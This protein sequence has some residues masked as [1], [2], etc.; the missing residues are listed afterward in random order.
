MKVLENRFT[1][2]PITEGKNAKYSDLIALSINRPLE[3]GVTTKEMRR[4][5]KILDKVEVAEHLIE[6]E[7]DEF[8]YVKS[9]IPAI[10]YPLKHRDLVLFED[11][12]NSID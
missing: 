3:R 6:L 12:I 11:Y 9:L 5:F 1:S 10:T 8:N 2:I 7:D 4:D